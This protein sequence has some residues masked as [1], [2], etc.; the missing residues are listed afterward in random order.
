MGAAGSKRF[1]SE[2]GNDEVVSFG[3]EDF[4][5]I[6]PK[7]SSRLVSQRTN[8][9]AVGGERHPIVDTKK[10]FVSDLSLSDYCDDKTSPRPESANKL[11]IPATH[12]TSR[13][14]KTDSPKD[15]SPRDS[16]IDDDLI[17]T[18][19]KNYSRLVREISEVD[20]TSLEPGHPPILSPYHDNPCDILESLKDVEC[21]QRISD[22]DSGCDYL[23]IESG[24]DKLSA[25]LSG[26]QDESGNLEEQLPNKKK[27]HRAAP[28]LGSLSIATPLSLQI[29][30]PTTTGDNKSNSLSKKNPNHH[31]RLRDGSDRSDS[32]ASGRSFM[33]PVTSD[34]DEDSLSL[35]G[36]GSIMHKVRMENQSLL[37][38]QRQRTI[39]TMHN[40]QVS[41]E[42]ISASGLLSKLH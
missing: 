5:V 41:C 9:E 13:D 42:Y 1:K 25:L 17:A 35:A 34:A 37:E 27:Q 12:A 22:K 29:T 6:E 11:A 8:D 40:A 36:Y 23:V 15:W 30:D 38:L 2:V 26:V 24:C 19:K 28:A 20:K 21:T 4:G 31:S 7:P 3:E 39:S 14:K 18:E 16:V 33:S 32:H 10:I